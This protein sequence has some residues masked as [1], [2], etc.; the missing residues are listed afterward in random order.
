MAL[1]N[2][3]WI[4][5]SN[6]HR[7]LATD[8]DLESPGLHKFYEPFLELRVRD[9]A[10]VIDLVRD[11][12]WV[13][14]S[15]GEE[16]RKQTHIPD[17]ARIEKYVIPLKGW[18][19][20]GGGS[21]EFMSSG[22]QN[23]EYLATLSALD[24][25]NFYDSL[26][27][28]DFIKAI[29]AE[30]KRHYDYTLIDSRTGF[31]DVADIC[32]VEL[33]DVLVDCF[34]LSTQG[35]D[36]AERVAR[37]VAE[38][39]GHRAIR[40]LPVPMR[41]DESEKEKL[42][43][44]R[45]F[46]E[47]KFE[48]LPAGMVDAQRRAYWNNVQ[49]PYRAYYAYEEVLAVFGDAPGQPGSILSAYE[50]LTGYI[51]D[52]A[53]TGM[54]PMD[55]D[56]RT[57]T[58]ARFDRKPPL[59]SKQVS[60]EFLAADQIWAEW[61]AA[62]LGRGGF[63]IRERPLD[64][65]SAA[66]DAAAPGWRTLAVVSAAYA[67]WRRGTPPADAEAG[68]A[69]AAAHAGRDL[70]VYVGGARSAPELAP[71]GVSLSAAREETV[72]VTRLERLLRITPEPGQLA[73]PLPRYPGAAPRVFEVGARIESFTG[74]EPDLRHLRD[75]LRSYSTAVV[76]PIALLGTAGVGKTSE[77]L[78]YAHRFANDYDFVAW[79]DCQR[80]AEIDYQVADLAQ[81]LQEQFGVATPAGATVAERARHVL[82][83]LSDGVT[84]AHWL[85][86]YDNAENIDAVREYLPSSGGQVL[87]TSRNQGWA[88]QAARSLTVGM[89][90]R[91]ESTL[92]LRRVVPSLT[93]SEADEV[94]EAL[95]DLPVAISAVAAFLRDT[96]YPVADY[97]RV[98]RSEPQ[99]AL[100]MRA[101]TDYPVSL[102]AAWDLPIKVLRDRSPAAARLL[103][104]CSV[105]APNISLDLV[106]YW[107]MAELLEPHDPALAEPLLMP[108]LVQEI[109]RLNLLKLDP[110]TN[111]IQ[112]HQL[113]QA[114]VRGAMPEEKLA[115][116]RADVQQLL[117]A[118]RPRRDADEP[119]TW[120][121]YR[122]IWP[123]LAPAE[124]VSSADDKVRR[125]II[126]RVRYIY[127]LRDLDRG[128]TEA[129]EAIARWET[130][131][132]SAGDAAQRTAL[133]TQLLQVRFNLANI[134]LFQSRYDDAR[135]LA[136]TVLAE[137]VQLLGP[138]HPHALMTAGTLAGT[139]R[140]LGRYRESLERDMQT[141]TT[142]V[143]QYGET[144]QRALQAANNLAESYRVNGEVIRALELDEETHR[145]YVATLGET[146][147]WT[148]FSARNLVRDRLDA[149]DYDVAA[150]EAR[151]AYQACAAALGADSPD[152]LDAQVLVGIALRSNGRPHEAAGQFDEAL[153]RLTARFGAA[154]VDA[155]ACRLSNSV[156]LLSLARPQDAEA[157]IRA[158]LA[159]YQRRLGASHPNVLACHVNLATA[160]RLQGRP[161]PSM[162]AARVA[163]EGLG[164]VLGSQHPWTLAA[165]VM[166][167]VLLADEDQRD[168]AARLETQ[169]AATLA[170]TM[171][172][173]HPDTLRCRANLLLTRKELGQETAGERER[174][175]ALLTE[176][177]GPGH[178]DIEP[179][180]AGRRVMRALDPQPF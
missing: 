113:I 17:H 147:P 97:L 104:L 108:R 52:G 132:E 9:A 154:S 173:H 158:V 61:I 143:R 49:V 45:V 82:G 127:V 123:H 13:A 145:R 77:A 71:A 134:L 5:A 165:H 146:H 179:V 34:T 126:D 141:L 86:I 80:A 95:G 54:P 48:N 138:D 36:G 180:L 115:R 151:R 163:A 91:A 37:H 41:V 164:R 3:A 162:A 10:G 166:E 109:S 96:L 50:R 16:E 8:W 90:S 55:E 18:A 24:W 140:A 103:E 6:G 119:L 137:Q 43:A 111:E 149:G 32:T 59:E 106:Y 79:I 120:P 35:V 155:L 76:R 129:T 84:V 44:S 110:S 74:R 28:G 160:L 42:E 144:H 62:V 15:S 29:R 100:G 85:M 33:P 31:S 1:A 156:N 23:R 131:L 142:W 2:V 69:E 73:A 38:L 26:N 122:L 11:Y 27:G 177:L 83:V 99:R 7:V 65:V 67:A 75:E 159:D 125:L 60:I 169:V 133:R 68:P 102:A 66:E 105:M 19:F 21:L 107:P 98:L 51:T 152:A 78:E 121:R 22:K 12:E 4:L 174:V 118:A 56:L 153:R 87:I 14:A 135:Q 176:R 167:A 25:D 81:R 114:V 117:L 124:V 20:P 128:V 72:A 150:D 63:V 101:P 112:V 139:L 171:G 175:I 136:E 172:E 53:V 168:Q 170:R 39:Y 89:F 88:D 157:E 40:I 30:M 116:T 161:E 93:A 58:R 46:A 94:A 92:H 70:A 148:L 178:P 130:M 47:R 57:A 64:G